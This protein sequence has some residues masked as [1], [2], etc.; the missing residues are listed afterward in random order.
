MGTESFTWIT[1][2]LVSGVA[3]GQA[4]AGPVVEHEGWRAAAATTA[5]VALVGALVLVGR[6]GYLSG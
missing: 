1:T 5:A 2:A 3:A 6:R 4:I